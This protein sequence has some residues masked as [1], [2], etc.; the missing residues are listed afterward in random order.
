[1]ALLDQAFISNDPTFNLRIRASVIAAAI[2]IS[3]ESTGTAFHQQRDQIAIAVLGSP[4]AMQSNFAFAV[5]SQPAVISDA[6]VNG[7]V[8]LNSTNA[9][10][11]V[12]LVTD[13]DINNAVASVWN[14]FFQH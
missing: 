3:N 4:L 7:T 1:M 11:Q 5:A 8:T 14:S 2:A 9:A 13:T 6:T 10:A 12:A